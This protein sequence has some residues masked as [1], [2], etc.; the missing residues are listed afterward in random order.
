V[1]LVAFCLL[2]TGLYLVLE[3]LVVRRPAQAGAFLGKI[4]SWMDS[5]RDHIIIVVS[6]ALGLWL[7][8]KGLYQVVT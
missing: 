3:V 7:I 6:L 2:A 1:A 4:R 5:H 8:G